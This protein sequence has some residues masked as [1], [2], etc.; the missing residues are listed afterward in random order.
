MK[1]LGKAGA[2]LALWAGFGCR[3]D[4]APLPEAHAAAIRDS[5]LET[6][7]T[8]GTVAGVPRA[9]VAA[10]MIRPFVN[11]S[12]GPEDAECGDAILG[13]LQDVSLVAAE[14]DAEA[15]GRPRAIG[16]LRP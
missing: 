11:V 12:A 9:A 14:P 3:A 13:A 1:N 5:L 10:I 8:G 16:S 2:C 6:I 7:D 4:A 15:P